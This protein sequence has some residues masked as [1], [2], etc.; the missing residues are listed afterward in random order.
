MHHY[1]IK[2]YITTVSLCNLHRYMFRHCLITIRQFTINALL[3]YILLTAAVEN[4][5]YKIKILQ[6]KLI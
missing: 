2:V 3:S 6:L 1:L 4:T 5:I